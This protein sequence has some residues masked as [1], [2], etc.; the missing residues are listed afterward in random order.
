MSLQLHRPD[1]KGG[2]EPRSVSDT[3]WR[4]SLQSRRWGMNR[5]DGRLPELKNPEM[6]PT[7]SWL[8]VAFW[9]G[10]AVLTFALLVIGYGTGFWHVVPPR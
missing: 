1:G 4:R 7:S 2:I 10:L 8:A 6:N 5:R 9:V 3:N